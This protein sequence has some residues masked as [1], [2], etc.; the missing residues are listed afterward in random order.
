MA[1]LLAFVQVGVVSEIPV[2]GV[3]A[4][5]SPLLVAFVGLLCGSTIGAVYGFATGLLIDLL[6]L[7]TLGLSSLIFTLVGYFAGRLRELRDPQAALTP[8]LVGAAAA[9]GSLVGYSLMEFMLGVD[10]PVS[11]ELLRQIVLITVVD[12]IIARAAVAGGARLAA[13]RA[14]RGPAPSPSP[15]P[16]LHDRRAQPALAPVS[17]IEPAGGREPRMPVSPQMALRVAI[18]GGLAMVLF[19]VI[20][21]RL[22]YLQILSGE[23]YV[24]Q[25]NVNRVRDLPIPAP[26]GQITDRTGQVLVSSRVTNAVQIV[27]SALPPEGAPRLHLYAKLGRLLGMTPRHV[28][29][30][31]IRGRTELPYAPV[32]IKTD[33]GPGVLTV[34]GEQANQFPG[35]VQTPVSIR[36]YPY[37]EMAAQVLGYVGVGLHA[38]QLKLKP[39]HGVEPG[40]IVGQ[41]GLEYYYDRYLRGKAGV[42]RVEVNAN[43]YPVPSRLAPTLP[44]A[45][46]SLQVTLDMGLQKEAEKA[47]LEGIDNA[48]AG[49]KP[50]VAGAFVAMD[51]RN[52]EV[53]ALGSYPSFNPNRFVK[54]MTQHEYEQLRGQ[55]RGRRPA[56]RPGRQ[57]HLSDRLHLQADHR[58]GGAG[59]R[60]DHARRRARGGPVH[61][62]LDRAVL[63]RRQSRLRRRGAGASAEGLLRHLLLRSRRARELL[64]RRDPEQGPPARDRTGHRHRPPER[65]RRRRPRRRL[66]PPREP[67][68]RSPA[69]TNTPRAA[70]GSSAKCAPGASATTCTWPSARATC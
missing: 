68:A 60:R 47:L 57:R 1:V 56:H 54:P 24:Q 40:T 15:S 12:T 18:I 52:G 63:Q 50:A 65:V 16:R 36:D 7:Q 14:A 30:L 22:W 9:G 5:L 2:F 41:E 62:R 42:E 35:V 46:H 32:T 25:A 39:F 21:F 51:P 20:F 26:R 61:L 49:G 27:P 3:N 64:R 66:A 11:F 53:L 13:E 44:Q 23:Q 4:D 37:G 33:A 29:A 28:Q 55:R 31:V 59:R 10:A 48:R 17:A 19:G 58:H 69:N 38:D 8:L 6:L 70:A 34:L 43:G 45:G 67:A